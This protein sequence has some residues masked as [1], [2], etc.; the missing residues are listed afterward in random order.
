MQKRYA[1]RIHATCNFDSTRNLKFG[2]VVFEKSQKLSKNGHK[3][4]IFTFRG[5]TQLDKNNERIRMS[6]RKQFLRIEPKI[7]G[8]AGVVFEN[9][10]KAEKNG[11]RTKI[12]NFQRAK[13][14]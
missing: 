3:I 8:M 10:Q 2:R 5:P 9:I 11:Q 1:E 13:T 12:L 4:N 6:F 7:S 14:S